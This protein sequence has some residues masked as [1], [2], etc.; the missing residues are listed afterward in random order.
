MEKFENWLMRKSEEVRIKVERIY[1]TWKINYTAKNP[2]MESKKLEHICD[3]KF[4]QITN[5]FKVIMISFCG[6]KFDLQI[7]WKSKRLHFKERNM[8]NGILY[9]SLEGG[10]VEFKDLSRITGYGKSLAKLCESFNI[11][12]DYSKTKFCHKFDNT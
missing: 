1:E 4:K 10:F 2:D 3:F 5:R 9:L 12:E 11:P 6:C 7:V 8:S